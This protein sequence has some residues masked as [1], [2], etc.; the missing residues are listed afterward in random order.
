MFFDEADALFGK[1]TNVKDAHDRYANL[2]VSYLLDRLETF[3]GLAVL[4]TN[5]KPAIGPAVL[6]RFNQI[7]PLTP[8]KPGRKRI[9]RVRKTSS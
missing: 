3:E 8:P 2:E 5:A 7:L 6:R 9:R 1:R 4:S